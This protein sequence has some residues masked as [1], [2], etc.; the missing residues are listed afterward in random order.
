MLGDRCGWR[1]RYVTM[2]QV[3]LSRGPYSTLSPS[4]STQTVRIRWDG[5]GAAAANVTTRRGGRVPMAAR[6]PNETRRILCP[7][8]RRS[9]EVPAPWSAGPRRFGTLAKGVKF[10]SCRRGLKFPTATL[11]LSAH[12]GS[13]RLSSAGAP[14]FPHAMAHV[15]L[16]DDRA[17]QAVVVRGAAQARLVPEQLVAHRLLHRHRAV[18][19]LRHHLRVVRGGA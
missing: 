18:E 10:P 2:S 4:S 19:H 8:A 16:G 12:R 13:S 11:S 3:G 1:H 17:A 15:I 14:H 9:P 5:C 7:S 6:V